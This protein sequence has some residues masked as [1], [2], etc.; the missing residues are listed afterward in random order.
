MQVE[1]RRRRHVAGHV[2]GAPHDDEA[3]DAPE[4][5]AVARQRERDVG[6]RAQRDEGQWLARTTQG[7]EDEVGAIEVRQRRLDRRPVE[8]AAE[9]VVAVVALSRHQRARQ[10]PGR[11]LGDHGD[12]RR[13]PQRQQA[14]E[15]TGGVGHL[16]VAGHGGEAG[17]AAPGRAPGVQQGQGVVDARVGVDQGEHGIPFCHGTVIYNGVTTSSA[18]G[19]SMDIEILYCGE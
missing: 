11:T 16:H 1:L 18:G 3:T 5:D 17:Q 12:G 13:P 7:V 2:D 4:R 10:R 8:E 9:A 15:V 19:L 6:E 14:K